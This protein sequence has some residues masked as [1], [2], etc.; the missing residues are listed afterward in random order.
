MIRWSGLRRSA[1]GSLPLLL[2]ECPHA[3]EPPGTVEYEGIDDRRYP[4][5]RIG[6][7][8]AG[9]H[10]CDRFVAAHD[11]R[12]REREFDVK[13]DKKIPKCRKLLLAQ[14]DP[15]VDGILVPNPVGEQIEPPLLILRR[16]GTAVLVDHGGDFLAIDH[17]VTSGPA[18]RWGRAR[19]PHQ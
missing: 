8:H 15:H 12:C 5:P 10:E 6:R 11:R 13:T 2:V 7:P 9:P 14:V 4:L 19:A 3:G 1:A 18:A 16:D 17:G